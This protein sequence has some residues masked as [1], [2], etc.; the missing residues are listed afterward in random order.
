LS[1]V[2]VEIDIIPRGKNI[3]SRHFAIN[4]LIRPHNGGKYTNFLMV[5]SGYDVLN[6][7]EKK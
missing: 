7:L 1:Y 4:R 3:G 6:T 2:E 5:I